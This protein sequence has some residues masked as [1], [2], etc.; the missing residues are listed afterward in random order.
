PLAAE[1]AGE[2]WV[3]EGDDEAAS[4][5]A[6]P[7]WIAA[8]AATL[9]GPVRPT[10]EAIYLALTRDTAT[11]SLPP[12]ERAARALAVAR[13]TSASPSLGP[14][15]GQALSARDR[16]ALAWSVLPNVFAGDGEPSRAPFE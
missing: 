13:R 15:A 4:E 11:R 7:P 16:A 10:F 3:P 2:P 5:A 9:P 12:A 14:R 8:A 1:P 6:P